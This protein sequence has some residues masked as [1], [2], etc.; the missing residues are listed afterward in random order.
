MTLNGVAKY[1]C[2]S[3]TTRGKQSHSFTKPPHTRLFAFV[4]EVLRTVQDNCPAAI[5]TGS[6]VR[7]DVFENSKGNLVVNE[8]ESLEAAYYSACSAKESYISDAMTEFFTT[9]LT[10][11]LDI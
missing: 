1:L 5:I 9:E 11:Y 4:Q 8:L 2:S 7:V 10:K 6:I 3:S